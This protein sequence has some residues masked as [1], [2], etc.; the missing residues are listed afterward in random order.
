MRAKVLLP[1]SGSLAFAF[2]FACLWQCVSSDTFNVT[3]SL[4][5]GPGSFTNA[6]ELANANPGPDIIEFVGVS[7]VNAQ[8]CPPAYP[9]P[10][11][12][13]AAAYGY[14]NDSVEIKGNGVKMA[15]LQVFV[16]SGGLITPL[17]SIC[18]NQPKSKD[19]IV[20]HTFGFLA[21][22][23][24]NVNVTVR[25]MTN[26][27]HEYILKT[28]D[29][30]DN[31]HI[32]LDGVKAERILPIVSCIQNAIELRSGSNMHLEIMDNQWDTIWNYEKTVPVPPYYFYNGAI[33]HFEKIIFIARIDTFEVI[34]SHR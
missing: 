16:T 26:F 14:V 20:Y 22:E 10:G 23:G 18:P 9:P 1:S 7:T 33:S 30:C 27:E 24:P 34:F 8:R 32:V 13:V 3:S 12:F 5:T 15:G 21:I 19:V 17:D 31:C 2:V 28:V 6:L 29:G 11:V 25:N 4:C